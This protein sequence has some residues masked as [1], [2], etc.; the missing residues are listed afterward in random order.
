MTLTPLPIRGLGDTVSPD[1]RRG[2]LT[3]GL[4][5]CVGVYVCMCV[6]LCTLKFLDFICS[7]ILSYIQLPYESIYIN[8][9]IFQN[10]F[11]ILNY[12][13]MM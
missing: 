12:L 4:C 7:P 1:L 13:N 9:I 11:D 5:V 6:T 10:T 2:A 3:L 8:N